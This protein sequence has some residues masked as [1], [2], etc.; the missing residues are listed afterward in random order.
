MIL[1]IEMRKLPKCLLEFKKLP[2]CPSASSNRHV[3]ACLC[4]DALA[5][6]IIH[7]RHNIRVDYLSNLLTL[8]FEHA[9]RI[10]TW[11]TGCK[12]ALFVALPNLVGFTLDAAVLEYELNYVIKGTRW[13]NSRYKGNPARS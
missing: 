3:V 5:L 11:A 4:T 9:L 7:W 8:V 1:E 10:R 13:I 2:N 6:I 12:V